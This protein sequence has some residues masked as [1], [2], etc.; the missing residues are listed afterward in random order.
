MSSRW[1]PYNW[2][3]AR[4]RLLL[5][6][7]LLVLLDR[8]C[9]LN[10]YGG[11]GYFKDIRKTKFGGKSQNFRSI[12][13]VML[14]SKGTFPEDASPQKSWRRFL[15]ID[16]EEFLLQEGRFQ[17]Q[18]REKHSDMGV[19]EEILQALGDTSSA[20]AT[21][22]TTQWHVS[23]QRK[24]INFYRIQK[25]TWKILKM[26]CLC[27]LHF[28]MLTLFVLGNTWLVHLWLSK[29]LRLPDTYLQ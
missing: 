18:R 27:L 14:K 23:K 16:F 29:L 25:T 5:W 9:A 11:E 7:L 21:F 6:G 1:L 24:H 19:R 13:W 10:T 12:A 15:P 17:Q 28:R 20:L 8:I 22:W 26:F 4:M 2:Q 3:Q